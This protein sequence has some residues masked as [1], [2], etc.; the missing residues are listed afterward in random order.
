M[1]AVFVVFTAFLAVLIAAI[2]RMYFNQLVPEGLPVDQHHKLRIV[3]LI[4]KLTGM[5]VSLS[6]Y[7]L[8]N[9]FVYSKS[10]MQLS[11][12]K[13]MMPYFAHAGSGFAM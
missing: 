10:V 12:L 7:K 6:N 11:S 3:G 2:L 1:V 9:V 13:S 4:T 5:V 8:F